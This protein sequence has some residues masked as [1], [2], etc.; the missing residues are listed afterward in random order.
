ML[1]AA[2]GT[3]ILVLRA[4]SHRS[5]RIGRLGTMVL[6]PGYYL[7]IGSAF[8]PGGLAARIRHH[9]RRTR[10]PHWHVDYLRR[11]TRLETVWCGH[12][13]RCEHEWAAAVA[14][15]PGAS[16]AL[17]GFGSSDCRCETHLYRFA[18]VP[19]MPVSAAI[20]YRIGRDPGWH[21][22]C[23]PMGMDEKQFK[24][25]LRDLAHGHHHPDEHDWST[26][27]KPASRSS[28]RKAAKSVPGKRRRRAK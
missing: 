4:C 21:E 17:A 28:G 14:A 27:A 9:Q 12:G 1:P 16:A 6:E 22:P 3:Y 15:L 11:H 18:A 24:K 8:G 10:R 20:P 25:H 7:Y 13:Q 19:S 2:R 5:V 26:D 23:E